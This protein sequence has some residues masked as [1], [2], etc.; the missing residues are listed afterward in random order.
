MFDVVFMGRKM[1]FGVVFMGR[2]RHLISTI[3]PN[4]AVTRFSLNVWKKEKVYGPSN[5]E[6]NQVGLDYFKVRVL[7]NL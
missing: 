7:L 4:W 2:K 5:G 1:A 6:K 3:S